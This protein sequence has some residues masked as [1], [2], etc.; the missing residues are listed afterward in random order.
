MR[1]I[2]FLSSN[3]KQNQQITFVFLLYVY[4]FQAIPE[5]K[6]LIN[7]YKPEILWS[8]GDGIAYSDYWESTEFLAW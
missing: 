2:N 7:T 6:E 5:M 1:S 4:I 8:D 3:L